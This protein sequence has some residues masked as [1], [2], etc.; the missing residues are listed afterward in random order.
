MCSYLFGIC[1]H[2]IFLYISG[3]PSIP[4]SGGRDLSGLTKLALMTIVSSNLLLHPCCGRLK[5]LLTPKELISTSLVMGHPFMM[6]RRKSRFFPHSC[7]HERPI[8][9]LVDVMYG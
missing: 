5:M 8:L 4:K 6:S 7:P 9:L 1:S 3:D 2:L